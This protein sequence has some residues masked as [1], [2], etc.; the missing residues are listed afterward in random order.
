LQRYFAIIALMTALLNAYKAG[1][2][3]NY[4]PFLLI[5]TLAFALIAS[6]FV[7]YAKRKQQK[8]TGRHTA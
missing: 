2:Q 5:L 4:S 6:I 3:D 8:P 7:E 1:F